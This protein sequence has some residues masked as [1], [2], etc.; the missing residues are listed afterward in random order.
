MG[1][2]TWAVDYVL[3]DME[4]RILGETVGYRDSRTAGMD[5]KVYER[6]PLKELYRRT[7]IQK[8]IFNTIYQLMA[9]KERHP[10]YMEQA[11]AMLMIPD[12]FHF[13]L[14]GVKKQEYTNATST[15]LVSTKTNDW[16]YELIERLGYKKELFQPIFMPEQWLV[17]LRRKFIRK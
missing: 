7:G 5:E 12:Y 3:L 1:I 16:D 14:T 6:I 17:I 8:Q 15:Q 11:E 10:E 9:V 13:R 2:D 4:D